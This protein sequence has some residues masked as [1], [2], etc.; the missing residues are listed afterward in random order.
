MVSSARAACE[1][2]EAEDRGDQQTTSCEPRERHEAPFCVGA[3]TGRARGAQT[4]TMRRL[5]R[6]G[7][8][9]GA[10]GTRRNGHR[11]GQPEHRAGTHRVVS[12]E[13]RGVQP[14]VRCIRST[15]R[16]SCLIRRCR[17]YWSVNMDMIPALSGRHLDADA[18]KQ[19][20]VLQHEKIRVLLDKARGVAERALGGKKRAAARLPDAISR[21]R[22]TVEVHLQFEE[23]ALAVILEEGG[24]SSRAA[25]RLVPARSR[26]AA[27]GSGATAPPGDG[28]VGAARPRGGAGVAVDLS[29]ERHG[30]GRADAGDR[31]AGSRDAGSGFHGCGCASAG[32]LK[33]IHCGGR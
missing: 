1:R 19:C 20:L 30:R 11:R 33:S 5:V 2:C 7:T 24:P 31:A 25:C 4:G 28:A 12:Q 17:G 3:E 18:A 32:A 8:G 15:L 27:R 29:H 26:A 9:N 16:G 23:R 13:G 14:A 6:S 10:P 21:I 22:R